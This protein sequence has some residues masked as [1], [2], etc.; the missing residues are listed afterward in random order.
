[1]THKHTP[2]ELLAACI[3]GVPVAIAFIY[4]VCSMIHGLAGPIALTLYILSFLGGT[5]FSVNWLT[6]LFAFVTLVCAPFAIPYSVL[7]YIANSM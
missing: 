1:M 7:V 6:N 3:V 5:L 2:L 4:L